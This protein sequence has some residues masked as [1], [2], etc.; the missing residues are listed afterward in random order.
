MKHKKNVDGHKVNK[1]HR[2]TPI[3]SNAIEI[4][5]ALRVSKVL[6]PYK[7][8]H[9]ELVPSMYRCPDVDYFLQRCLCFVIRMQFPVL[10]HSVFGN[11]FSILDSTEIDEI[12]PFW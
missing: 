3:S 9:I 7:Q 2:H 6:N 8:I 11:L 4:D 12:V 5:V 1:A 10:V